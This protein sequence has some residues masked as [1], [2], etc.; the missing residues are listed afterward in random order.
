MGIRGFFGALNRGGLLRQT[1]LSEYANSTLLIDT[2][3][4]KF[5]FVPLLDA[6]HRW[7][8]EDVATHL[9]AF[10]QSFR[11]VV[12]VKDGAI[13]ATQAQ[14]KKRADRFGGRY[15][16]SRTAARWLVHGGQE[17]PNC[18][19]RVLDDTVQATLAGVCDRHITAV[20]E[21]DDVIMQMAL[22]NRNC[23]ILT[24]DTDFCKIPCTIV[25]AKPLWRTLDA[26]RRNGGAR[27]R[28]ALVETTDTRSA[29]VEDLL[30]S[31]RERR[32]SHVPVPHAMTQ[33]HCVSKRPFPPSFMDLWRQGVMSGGLADKAGQALSSVSPCIEHS[34]VSSP[35]RAVS[36]QAEVCLANLALRFSASFSRDTVV[37]ES[38]RGRQ[39]VKLT[40]PLTGTVTLPGGST[41][42]LPT[43]SEVFPPNGPANG[44]ERDRFVAAAG[45][46]TTDTAV[47][48]GDRLHVQRCMLLSVITR[49][50]LLGVIPAHRLLTLALLLC[51]PEAGVELPRRTRAHP[52]DGDTY[53]L[54]NACLPIVRDY[55]SLGPDRYVPALFPLCDHRRCIAMA[56]EVRT[57]CAPLVTPRVYSAADLLGALLGGVDTMGGRR[58]VGEVLMGIPLLQE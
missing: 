47:L 55:L 22:E 8:P 19:L 44:A 12:S 50:V 31:F 38:Y 14:L 24:G 54:L 18:L 33:R 10:F 27:R 56:A 17:A 57:E 20:S 41:L 52:D 5:S 13:G 28:A 49:E 23:V 35:G 2:S 53:G 4:L 25:W 32:I 58:V 42:P 34:H 40:F 1:R 7:S 48:T 15:D 11:E 39:P 45:F 51:G 16:D 36:I 29:K 6:D 9:R 26:I 21:A 43:F 37:V 3:A 30:R 46:N